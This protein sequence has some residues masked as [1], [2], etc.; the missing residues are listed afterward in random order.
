MSKDITYKIK[1]SVDLFLSNETY[2]M[3]YYMNSRQRKSFRVNKEMVILIEMIDGETPLSKVKDRLKSE[4]NIN[5]SYVDFIIELMVR[6]RIVAPISKDVNEINETDLVRFTRQINYFTEFL[7]SEVMGINAQIKLMKSKVIIFG[8]GAIGGNIAL[9]LVMSGVRNITL[10]DDD[11]VEK[12]DISRHLFYKEKY[13]GMKKT[14]ALKEE[15]VDVDNNVLVK[16]IN[17]YMYPESKIEQE[18][19]EAD[20]IINT[21]DEPYIGYTSSK[22]SRVCVKYNKPHYIAGGFDAHLASTGEL[23]IPYVTPCVDCYASYFKVK[24]KD[25]KPK[26]HPVRERFREIGGLSSMALFSSSYACIE[27]IK[28]LSG[29]IEMKKEYKARG[30][31]LIDNMTITY[32]DLQRNSSC[33]I[34]G[35]RAN[36]NEP[37]A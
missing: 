6:N 34:C 11:I 12:S 24:L 14:F 35:G 36:T 16:C 10:F 9:E 4:Y 2:L 32:L 19:M 20:F 33:P 28:Y 5:P 27:I 15:L 3:A 18:I 13:I 26:K 37:K 25:W 1:D 30:E 31:F 21:L 23:I 22:I 17:N 8:C 29:I 7:D